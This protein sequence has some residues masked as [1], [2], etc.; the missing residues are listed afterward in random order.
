L[1]RN[2]YNDEDDVRQVNQGFDDHL[3]PMDVMW[4]DIGH[5]DGKRYMTWDSNQFPNPVKMQRNLSSVARKMVTIVDPHVKK[6]D[7]YDLNTQ[8][9]STIFTHY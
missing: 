2:N 3:M 4:L 5:T 1:S 9:N 7:H 8:V 6:D